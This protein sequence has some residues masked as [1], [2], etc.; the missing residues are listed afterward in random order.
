MILKNLSKLLS[1]YLRHNPAEINIQIDKD[2]WTDIPILITNLER[3]KAVKTTKQEL[4]D[5]VNNFDKKRFEIK[6]DKIRALYGHSISLIKDGAIK[7]PNTLFHGTHPNNLDSIKEKGIL[8]MSRDYVHLSTTQDIATEVGRRKV[9]K[10]IVLVVNAQKMFLD[11]F[12]F[13]KGNDKIWLTTHVPPKF[14]Q[15]LTKLSSNKMKFISK[16]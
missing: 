8:A 4:E 7:P 13:F 6:D 5:C 11:G 3:Y 15:G 9:S 14:I 12:Q 10:P 2:G 16:A 1:V